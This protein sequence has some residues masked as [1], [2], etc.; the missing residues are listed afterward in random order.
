MQTLEIDN[1]NIIQ[2]NDMNFLAQAKI[3]FVIPLNHKH[4]MGAIIRAL[5]EKNYQ[6]NIESNTLEEAF[7]Q[8]GENK[9]NENVKAEIELRE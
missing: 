3:D 5:D 4:Q 1:E 2:F 9:S 6:Y 7:I 8:L